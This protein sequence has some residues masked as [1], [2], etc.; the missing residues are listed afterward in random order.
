MHSFEETRLLPCASRD[1][2]DVVMDIEAYPQF[3]PWVAAARILRRSGD[4]LDAELVAEFAGMRHSF[5]TTD[6]FLAGKMIEIRLKQGPFRF[7]ESYWSF[8]DLGPESCRVHFSIE[9][10]FR[11]LMLDVVAAPVFTT[12]CR[13]M[14]AAFERR[15][16]QGKGKHA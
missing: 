12:A 1:L 8:D 13:Q 16:L 14:V 2:Y 11:N 5:Q 4:D 10:A 9:F 7:L 3:L 6:R 15:A